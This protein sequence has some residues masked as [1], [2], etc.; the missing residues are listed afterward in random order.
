MSWR[1]HPIGRR[2]AR[3]GGRGALATRSSSFN[4]PGQG[5]ENRSPKRG[6]VAFSGD[7]WGI[8]VTSR[9]ILAKW[10][11]SIVALLMVSLPILLLIMLGQYATESKQVLDART[12][13]TS[14]IDHASEVKVET[15]YDIVENA[16]KGETLFTHCVE[17]LREAAL[18]GSRET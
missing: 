3:L 1:G 13:I 17:V 11:Y 18:H 7:W 5:F 15:I 10:I 8:D 2:P 12:S 6:R 9:S 14:C 16:G 4:G